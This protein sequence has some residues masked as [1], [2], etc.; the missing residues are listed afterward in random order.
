MDLKRVCVVLVL[1]TVIV[2]VVFA[3]TSNPFA[4]TSWRATNPM[5]QVITIEFTRVNNNGVGVCVFLAPSIDEEATYTYYGN[6]VTIKM[7][8][9]NGI[10]TGVIQGNRLILTIRGESF[11]FTKQ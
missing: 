5:N 4:N 11:T 6:T 1:V 9:D 8:K 2:G 10:A 3:Q 7:K